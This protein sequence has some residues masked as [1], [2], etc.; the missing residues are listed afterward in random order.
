M[1]HLGAWPPAQADLSRCHPLL[2]FPVKEGLPPARICLAPTPLLSPSPPPSSANSSQGLL[3]QP[4]HVPA[5][6]HTDAKPSLFPQPIS[7]TTSPVFSLKA[8]QRLHA[9]RWCTFR[10]QSILPRG[11]RLQQWLP[12]GH[13]PPCSEPAHPRR[14][15][16]C[17]YSSR[18][19]QALSIGCM[20]ILGRSLLWGLSLACALPRAV[21]PGQGVR[22]CMCTR[23]TV[24]LL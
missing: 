2:P 21:Q 1:S 22:V 4:R 18:C 14:G 6:C 12:A 17:Q 19:T 9:Q 10:E 15:R 20:S 23:P 7:S 3:L 16:C 11:S 5:H 8:A 13:I 24:L